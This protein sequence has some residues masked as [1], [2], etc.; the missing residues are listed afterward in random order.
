MSQA[1][2]DDLRRPDCNP[3]V[4]AP[5]GPLRLDGGLAIVRLHQLVC[6]NAKN[7]NSAETIITAHKLDDSRQGWELMTY[8]N[9]IICVVAADTILADAMRDLVRD[10]GRD[11]CVVVASLDGVDRL[12]D[13]DLIEAIL[14]HRSTH[15]E[16]PEKFSDLL[17]RYTVVTF[18]KPDDAT[19]NPNSPASRAKY[20]LRHPA[21]STDLQ[22]LFNQLARP[23]QVERSTETFRPL[24]LYRGL[25]GESEVVRDLK[26][27]IDR[28]APTKGNILVLGETGTG[29]EV[30]ARNIHY[31]S[32]NNGGPFIPV[33]CSAIPADLLESELFGH[34]KGAFTGAVSDRKGRFELA[35]GGTLFLDEIGDMPPVLQVK[36]LR[37]LEE[38]KIYRL[39]G[40]SAVPM[41]ARL[42]AATHRDLEERVEQGAFR[43][44][45]FY[46]LNVI[47]VRVPPLRD[48]SEDI[49]DL[50]RELN[51]RRKHEHHVTIEFSAAASECLQ[52]YQWPGN[53]RE[54]ANLVE[55]L[56]VLH[57]DGHI[58]ES[59]LPTEIRGIPDEPYESS[60]EELKLNGSFDL[61]T[62]LSSTEARLIRQALECSG[63][64]IARAA[65]LLH[66]RRTTLAE[67][68]RRLD[69]TDAV[70]S[71][72]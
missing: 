55:R 56:T 69:L 37:V 57:P 21:D 47:P 54:L 29:K 19:E 61:K 35:S 6:L 11:R 51:F 3:G 32:V 1:E 38:R 5:M 14:L 31:R 70:K 12:P 64:V 44:D 34:K 66:V 17:K 36:L 41:T 45:L 43:E 2:V 23:R 40:D 72:G 13:K 9:E 63:G 20:Q 58:E 16:D 49:P 62:Y 68:V 50:I 26:S 27:V 7:A 30:V 33:N 15:V 48:R 59:D 28:V 53:I 46:R 60:K 8:R 65:E 25:V 10:S 24:Q 67:K 52:H 4:P 71:T 22:R 18:G 39:G 42:I